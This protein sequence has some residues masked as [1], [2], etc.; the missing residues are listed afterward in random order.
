MSI[1]WPVDAPI[2]AVTHSWLADFRQS[3][4]YSSGIRTVVE[5]LENWEPKGKFCILLLDAFGPFLQSIDSEEFQ[6]LQRTL[7]EANGILWI[8]AGGIVGGCLP[9]FGLSQ[10]LL[11]TLRMEDHGKRLISLDLEPESNV[12]SRETSDFVQKVI[13]SSFNLNEDHHQIDCEFAVR[14]S[15]LHVSRLFEDQEEDKAISASPATSQHERADFVESEIPLKVDIETTGLLD[16]LR[17]VENEVMYEP[18]PD[19]YIELEPKAFG[20]NFRDVLITLGHIDGNHLGYECSGVITRVGKG[21][22]SSQFKVGDRICAVMQGHFGTP[23]RVHW[24]WAGHIPEDASFEE[25]AAIPMVFMTAYQSLFVSA[26][27]KEG[28]SVLIHAANGGVGQAAN[29]TDLQT[30]KLQLTTFEPIR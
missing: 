16:S 18:L 20:V 22:D 8:S 2:S 6:H 12:W 4:H 28:E 26:R 9:E 11:R 21:V 5:P 14:G 27:L 7:L 3:L 24:M 10:G 19:D 29:T 17:F 13:M 23:V 25:A 15:A 1:I 30:E